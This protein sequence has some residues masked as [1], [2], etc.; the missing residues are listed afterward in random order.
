[1][2][3]IHQLLIAATVINKTSKVTNKNNNYNFC[4]DDKLKKYFC[5]D[6][7]KCYTQR[8]NLKQHID[9]FHLK[10][11]YKCCICNFKTGRK[12][13]LKLHME[14]HLKIEKKKN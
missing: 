5:S 9:S 11:R 7:N 4:S 12:Y 13:Y 14:R 2:K 1:M 3:G 6:C 10:I 8:K